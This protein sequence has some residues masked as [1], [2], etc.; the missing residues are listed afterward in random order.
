[1][2]AVSTPTIEWTTERR[3]RLG[4][5]IARLLDRTDLEQSFADHYAEATIHDDTALNVALREE[6]GVYGEDHMK[7][8]LEGE[9]V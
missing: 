6:V 9:N 2:N 8:I 7:K 4:L 1:M 5:H 3:R